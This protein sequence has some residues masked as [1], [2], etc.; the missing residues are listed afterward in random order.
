MHS[1]CHICSK[2]DAKPARY[3]HN[4]NEK[5]LN[6]NEKIQQREKIDK[7]FTEALSKKKKAQG[8][9]LVKCVGRTIHKFKM[10]RCLLSDAWN[11]DQ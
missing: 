7:F 4:Q 10:R 3:T 6:G 1:S 8:R 5:I 11:R 9:T 2:S